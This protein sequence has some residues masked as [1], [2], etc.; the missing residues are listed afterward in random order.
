[1]PVQPTWDDEIEN[2]K[3][4]TIS[5]LFLFKVGFVFFWAED[6]LS[7]FRRKLITDKEGRGGAFSAC[8][9]SATLSLS[10]SSVFLFSWSTLLVL[11]YSSVFL[12][13]LHAFF[14]SNNSA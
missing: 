5:K 6:K 13:S 14:F 11:R 2:A 1:M 9:T 12:S 3:Q 8:R 4:V 7:R 10:I